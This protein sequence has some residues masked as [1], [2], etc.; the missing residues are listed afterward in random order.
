MTKFNLSHYSNINQ[1]QK[2]VTHILMCQNDMVHGCILH[3]TKRKNRDKEDN[4]F[5][6]A[7]AMMASYGKT[8]YT[9]LLNLQNGIIRSSANS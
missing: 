2:E 7:I 1:S 3:S 6:Q 9:Q 5:Q 8:Q 4:K